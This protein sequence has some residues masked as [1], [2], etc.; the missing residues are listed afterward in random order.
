M[1][2]VPLAMGT[3]LWK[4]R[5]KLFK[6]TKQMI[7]GQMLG[8]DRPEKSS[9]RCSFESARFRVLDRHRSRK[10]TTASWILNGARSLGAP[11]HPRVTVF[12]TRSVLRGGRRPGVWY[13]SFCPRVR[14]KQ[15]TK[16]LVPSPMAKNRPLSGM[17]EERRTPW[18]TSRLLDHGSTWYLRGRHI[19]SVALPDTKRV[20]RG[21]I[22]CR[23]R[24]SIVT[25]AVFDQRVDIF[26][27]QCTGSAACSRVKK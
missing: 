18:A 14:K 1:I 2:S 7:P 17:G 13:K 26:Q 16:I 22:L 23:H 15:T 9:A 8:Q 4:K 5:F 10:P 12:S 20:G 27:R 25:W 3:N 6:K 21:L 19:H 24:R 11:T